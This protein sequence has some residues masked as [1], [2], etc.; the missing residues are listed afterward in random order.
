MYIARM[1]VDSEKARQKIQIEVISIYS[2]GEHLIGCKK[3]K[4][5]RVTLHKMILGL[6]S[7]S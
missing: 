5:T 2:L 6:S 1:Y 3:K 4:T 7:E